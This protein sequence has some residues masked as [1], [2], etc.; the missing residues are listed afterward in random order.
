MIK[1]DEEAVLAGVEEGSEFGDLVAEFYQGL[2]ARCS[3]KNNTKKSVK[4]GSL[5]PG[6]TA[7]SVAA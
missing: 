1:Q 4:N 2:R 6:T 5:T 7:G 3:L